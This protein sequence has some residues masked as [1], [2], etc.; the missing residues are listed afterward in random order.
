MMERRNQRSTSPTM[1]LANIAL[2]IGAALGS[3]CLVWTLG[4]WMAGAQALVFQSGS[5]SPAIH[6][7]D[8]AFSRSVPADE[9]QRGDIVSV[10]T[11]GGTRI[12]HRVVEA[13]DMAADPPSEFMLREHGHEAAGHDDIGHAR[14]V[15]QGDAN[16]SPDQL[17]YFVPSVDRVDAVVHEVGWVLDLARH[18]I[19]YVLGLLLTAGCLTCGLLLLRHSKASEARAGETRGEVRD[20][21]TPRRSRAKRGKQVGTLTA[22]AIILPVAAISLTP[23][24]ASDTLAY[25][26]DTPKITGTAGG[27]HTAPWMTCKHVA[28]TSGA[29]LYYRM[30]ESSGTSAA[31][32]SGNGYTGT[33]GTRQFTGASQYTLGQTG[34]CARMVDKA[35]KFRREAFLASPNVAINPAAGGAGQRWNTLTISGWFRAPS[36]SPGGSIIGFTPA[37]PSSWS[38]FRVADRRIT[39]DSS[40]RIRFGV[41][42]DQGYTIVTPAGTDYTDN[43]WHHVAAT[44]SSSGMRLFVD[45]TPVDAPTTEQGPAASSITSGIQWGSFYINAHWLVGES[46]DDGWT[47][48]V[49]TTQFDGWINDVGVW[50]RVLTDGEIRDLYRAAI[51]SVP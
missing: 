18:P 8:L 1:R 19:A 43:T 21:E 11:E 29:F 34:N 35:V 13:A 38:P 2:S 23:A 3:L 25:F 36:T 32:A 27:L 48:A 30:E 39:V 42:S 14:L 5:M 12:T 10:V 24:S 15:L 9:V 51:R 33:Y 37:L 28:E 40:G 4:L 44:L 16:A 46:S 49:N 7:G 6:T 41:W 45:G 26:S 31:D 50:T 22:I 20:D 47:P 17:P